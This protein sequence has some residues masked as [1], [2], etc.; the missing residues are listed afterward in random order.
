VYFFT[1]FFPTAFFSQKKKKKETIAAN[2][3][4]RLV[5]TYTG[6]GG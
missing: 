6:R 5:N 4:F 3:V 2:A 1:L